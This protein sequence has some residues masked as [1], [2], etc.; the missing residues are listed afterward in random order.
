MELSDGVIEW[1]GVGADGGVARPL[2]NQMLVLGGGTGEDGS[3]DYG[4]DV[5]KGELPGHFRNSCW[6]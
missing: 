1:G 4:T 6:F 2:L 5:G 3:D